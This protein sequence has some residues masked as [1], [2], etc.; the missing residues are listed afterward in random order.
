M[1]AGSPSPPNSVNEDTIS[2]QV[3]V[4]AEKQRVLLERILARLENVEQNIRVGFERLEEL[5]ADEKK[6]IEQGSIKEEVV[7]VP[8]PPSVLQGMIP[9]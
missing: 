7:A 4:A 9:S 8:E 1:F 2:L 5:R 3:N 6:E